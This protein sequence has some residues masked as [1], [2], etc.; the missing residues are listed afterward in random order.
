MMAADFDSVVHHWAGQG[1]N[2][3]VLA[4]LL[5]NPS[6][7]VEVIVDDYCRKGFGP[8]APAVRAYFDAL[9]GQTSAL[10]AA[11]PAAFRGWNREFPET[12][13]QQFSP[14]ALAALR[15]HLD[16]ARQLAAGDARVLE[17]I[18]FLARGLEYARLQ[19]EAVRAVQAAGQGGDAAAARAA[20]EARERFLR[21][22]LYGFAL[23]VSNIAWFQAS[24][25]TLFFGSTQAAKGQKK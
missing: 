18:D 11:M 12:M 17:R 1:L 13:L 6:A 22:N 21:E 23:G 16:K 14:E 7:D 4:R 8:A 5:W 19:T 2:Y 3:Y 25:K 24:R 9:Q 15:G 20:V 10:A